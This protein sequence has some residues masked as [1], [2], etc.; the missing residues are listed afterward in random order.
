MPTWRTRAEAGRASKQAV[1][2]RGARAENPRVAKPIPYHL[3]ITEHPVYL[4]A[5]VTGTHNADNALRFLTEAFAA[6]AKTGRSALLLEFNLSGKS[7]DSSSI[8]DVVSKRTNLAVKLRKIAYVDN[9]ERDPEKVKFAE[10]VARNR[11]VNVRLFKE[12]D[13]AKTWLTEG[14]G[15]G[16]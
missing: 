8:F 3:V 6:C 15:N 14:P 7:L 4:Q 10:T 2:P 1:D 13:S 11:G 12:L 16:K 5:T 9:S